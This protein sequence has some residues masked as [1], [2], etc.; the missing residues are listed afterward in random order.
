M[1]LETAIKKTSF[2]ISLLIL[3]ALAL[4][5]P[6]VEYRAS[7]Y[8]QIPI[9]IRVMAVVVIVVSI[10]VCMICLSCR[11]KRAAVFALTPVLALSALL[12][13]LPQKI[14]YVI[15]F[16]DQMNHAGRI[17]DILAT[18]NVPHIIYPGMHIDAAVLSL[19]T[20]LS[21]ALLLSVLSSLAGVCFFCMTIILARYVRVPSAAALVFAPLVIT[22]TG[23]VP[24]TFTYMLLLPVVAYSTLRY[25]NGIRDQAT[26]V[27]WALCTG[28][29]ASIMWMFHVV[30]AVIATIFVSLVVATQWL[31]RV[32]VRMPELAIVHCLRRTISRMDIRTP[33]SSHQQP[34]RNL[35]QIGLVGF[36]WTTF[37][38]LFDRMVTIASSWFVPH[39]TRPPSLNMKS[40]S[41]TL[42]GEFGLSLLDVVIL[43]ARKYGALVIVCLSAGVGVIICLQLIRTNRRYYLPVTVAVLIVGSGIWSALEM[44]IGIVPRLNFIRVLSPVRYLGIVA[45][46]IAVYT[47]LR[48]GAHLLSSVTGGMAKRT[49]A[50][51]SGSIIIVLVTSL[52]AGVSVISAA[53]AYNTPAT[54]QANRQVLPSDI[55]GMSWYFTYKDRSINTTTLWRYNFRYINFLYRPKV[56]ESRADELDAGALSRGYRS[57]AHFGYPNNTTFFQTVGCKYYIEGS[58][59]RAIHLQARVSEQF[60]PSDFERLERDPTVKQV[61]T[62]GNIHLSKV[63]NCSDSSE[64]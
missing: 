20:G 41:N 17:R 39:D 40:L 43:A 5:S 62:N 12:P 61:Y 33:S 47:A 53:G 4:L 64:L 1:D 50:I 27:S 28:F 14:G 34:T 46:G 13:F 63:G 38:V 44:T 16:S 21:P 6:V 49:S 19:F 8:T 26:W 9:I 52:V 57:P 51:V 29:V 18:G 48:L 60:I 42:F 11:H 59:D 54:Y 23:A 30:P 37:T 10:A 2:S 15:G 24:G 36:L 22:P 32:F 45:S 7:I 3:A 25:A 55:E 58:Y 35:L 56:R 31:Q